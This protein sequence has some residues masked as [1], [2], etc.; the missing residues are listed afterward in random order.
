[1][2]NVYMVSYDLHRPGQDYDDLIDELKLSRAW[3]HHLES[4]WLIYT[5]ENAEEL[6]HRLRPY[7]D[8]NDELL[9]MRVCDES[10]GWLKP[11]AW[12]WIDKHVPNCD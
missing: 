4:T 9:V 12:R 5:D 3:W 10:F 1:M 7:L 11:R 2:A 6:F 8:G